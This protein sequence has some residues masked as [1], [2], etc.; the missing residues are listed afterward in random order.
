MK[1]LGWALIQSDCCCLYKN[2]EFG[3]T[4]TQQGCT[5]VTGPPCDE[6]A[7]GRQSTR[8]EASEESNPTAH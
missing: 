6:A 8:R 5:G 3:Y 2:R 7:R 4:K 1:L